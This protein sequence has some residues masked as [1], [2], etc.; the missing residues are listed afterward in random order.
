MYRNRA[1]R[2]RI[3]GLAL[4]VLLALL[5]PAGAGAQTVSSPQVTGVEMTP[6][7]RRTLKQLEEQWLQWIV[8]NN[9]A[10]AN[11][12]VEGLM[13][14]ARQLGMTRLP[15][16]SA[17]AAA[18]AVQAAR[19]KDFPRARWALKAAERFDPG[20]PETAFA[21]SRVNRLEGNYP[22]AVVSFLSGCPRLFSRPLE[23]YLWL[24]DLGLW[25]L[26]LLLLTGG[27]FVAVQMAT[28]GGGLFHD[29]ADAFARRLPRPVAL[30]LAALSLLWPIL[31]PYGL[32]WLPLY[33]SVL[34]WGYGSSSERVVLVAVWLL[35]GVTP[36]LITEQRRRVAL[37]LSPPVRAME[38]LE[39]HRL[40]GGLFADLGVLRSL[41]PESVAVKHFLADVHR[42]LGQWE[43][44][45]SLYRQ[46]LEAEPENAPALLNLGTYFF[47]KG[48]FGSA[49]QSFQ[50][51]TAADPQ[52]A[53]AQFNLSQAYSESY[54]FDESRSALAQA[55]EIDDAR[56]SGWVSEQQRVVTVSG[57]LERTS[58]IRRELLAGW[59]NG[60][61][62][63]SRPDL[64][65]RFLPLL[66]ALGLFLASAALHL[67]RRPFG[68]PER[69]L[70]ARSGGFERWRR[71]LVPGFASSEVGEGGQ[72]FAALLV[73]AAL[74]MLPLFGTLGYPIPWSYDPGNLASWILMILGLLLYLGVRLRRELRDEV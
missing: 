61:K 66:V 51:V 46:V 68:Y 4:G 71:V 55:R 45:R 21:E 56:V 26:C 27:L 15:D 39:Q 12:A 19:E 29:I 10:Q 43:L 70:D 14:T 18:R 58:E 41:L 24:Q 34:L 2:T 67:A 72:A 33:W 11:S 54:L 64:F 60:E 63:S 22:G 44:A 13:T 25:G 9:E 69:R 32:L 74:L 52:N 62:A 73:P 23:R 47:L 36:L 65:Q 1:D 57:G 38:S 7:V 5:A 8:Q 28:K 31:L 50:K 16:L 42:S 35:V 20:R 40:Y 49:I 3:A 37:T 17:G 30:G 53:A 59:R 6:T 48:D